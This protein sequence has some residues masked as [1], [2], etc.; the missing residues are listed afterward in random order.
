MPRREDIQK[1]LL[2]GSGPIV[3]GQAA[4]FDYSGVQACKVLLEE[5]FEV[6][7]VNSNPAT[8]MTDPEFATATYIEPLLPGP[9]T[10]IIEKERPDALLPTLGGQTAL[11]L[12]MTLHEDGTL[13]KFGVELIG[14]DAAAI[15]RAEDREEFRTTMNEAGIRIPWSMTVETLGEVEEALA[16]GRVTLPAIIRPAFTMGGQGGGIGRTETELRQVVTEGLAASPINQVLVEESVIG[17]GEFEL[18]V[19]R[20]RNDNV[21]IICSIENVDPM[22]VHTGD[23]VTVAPAQTLSDPLY[24]ELRD[25]AIKV[26]R[27]IGVETGGSNVQFAVDPESGEIAVIE[28]NPRVSRSSA[29]ASKATGFPIAKMAAKLAVGYALEEIP[30]DITRAT[31]ASFEPTIDYVV[32]KIPRFAFEKFPGADGRLSTFMQSVGEAMAIGRTF[33]ESFAKAMRSR[34]LDA[35]ADVPAGDEELLVAIEKPCAERFDLILAA[36]E[37][38]LDLEA[39]H[40]ACLVD[41]WFLRELQL[42]ATEGDGTE[43]LVRTYKAVDTCAAE[44]EAA[45]PYYYSGHER[46]RADGSPPASEVRR[47]TGRESVVILGAGPNRIGQGIEFDYC[48]VHAAMTARELGRDA[49]MVNC[50]P[51]TVST[52][53]DTS[54]RLYFEP[55]TAED[56]LAVCAQEQPEGVIVQ[57]G[58]QTPLKLARTLEEAGVRLLGTP[59]DAIDLAEDRGQFGALLRRLGIKHPP[60]GTAFSAEEADA[61]AED[62]GFPLLVR[63]S[64]V[65]GGRAMEICYSTADLNAYLKAHVKA[66]QE[67]PLLL[68]RFL[69]N[70]IEVDVDALGDGED[71]WVAGIMQHVEEAGVHSGDSACVIPPLSLGEEMLEE[72][73]ATTR[74][75]ALEL[76][77]I[78]LLN[79]QYGVA[80]GELYVIEANPRASR[81][82]P[83][84]SKAIG[85]PLAKMAARLMLGERLADQE[86]PEGPLGH[87]SVKEAVL[88]FA[89][90]A[91]ADSVLGPEMKSTGEVMGIAADFPT[92]FGKAQAAAGVRLPE[93]GSV[94][95][96]VTDTDKPAATQLAARFHDLGFEVIATGG[97][98]QAITQMGVPVTRINKLGEGSPHVV[99]LIEE[100]RCDLVINTPTG[101][102]ARADGYEIRTAAVRHGIPC[103]TTMTG[104]TAAARAIAAG[105]QGDAEVRSIQEIHGR[106]R[107][108]L[109]R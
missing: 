16:D 86:L 59:V 4:E 102:G 77:V 103:V 21:V 69:E 19:M 96:T 100:R 44:F 79:I 56:V 46:P 72:I 104:A 50:N 34:E 94:F 98:A 37:R 92:A 61:V 90:F 33:R 109:P 78:G 70:A 51:E 107:A 53:Y 28:M 38:G 20:D 85:V 35:P 64:Y 62:V 52:D 60:Y 93:E 97:T 27:A 11:N 7:L 48:C 22:G 2:I 80:A 31:P 67:H 99:D 105:R 66:D 6:V 83:F 14:A 65:L 95:I 84:V 82:V 54:D 55:L 25:I 36:F 41:R 1:I 68:D 74:K 13:E 81:T 91:G 17:W 63:P 26:I 106:A 71:V 23:S 73:R 45:T 47:D 39:V 89:R 108:A 88:P 12:A 42:L 24:Q 57:F 10:K 76:G 49:V 30:N 5:G 3:I 9:V 87:V 29:L 101:S 18:E 75:I 58:G 40:A 43:G 32:T 8:I 15:N